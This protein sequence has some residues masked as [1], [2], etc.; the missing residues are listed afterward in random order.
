MQDFKHLVVWNKAHALFLACY[1]SLGTG[2]PGTS[3]GLRSQLLRAA[4]SV[5]ANIAEGCGKVS[6][7]EFVRFLEISVGSA[8][9]L[10]NHLIVARDIVAVSHDSF[11]ALNEMLTE[12]R[13]MLIGLVKA[14]RAQLASA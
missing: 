3:F 4:A 7:K 6:T 1:R 9:E 11:A 13:R 2:S 5:P 14:L 10:E 12:V 8:R